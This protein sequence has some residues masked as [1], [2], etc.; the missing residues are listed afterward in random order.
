MLR[1]AVIMTAVRC[2]DTLF[3]YDLP[4]VV[5][6]RDEIGGSYVG[7]LMANCHDRYLVTGV[8]PTQLQRFKR[9]E[10]DLRSIVAPSA[11][12]RYF[13][14][15]G[16]LS[17]PLALTPM[18]CAE[19][20]ERHLPEAGFLLHD[21]PA[22]TAVVAEARSRNNFVLDLSVDPP[23]SADGHRIAANTLTGLLQHIQTLIKHAYGAALREL[24]APAR[25]E[26]DRSDAARLDVIVPAAPGSFRIVLE[27]GRRADLLGDSELTR[28]MHRVDLLFEG[29]DHPRDVLARLREHKG[30]LAGAFS[31]LVKFLASHDTSLV[32]QWATPGLETA[33]TRRVTRSQST[34]LVELLSGVSN[35]GS[36]PIVLEGLLE[37]ADLTRRSWRLLIDGARE[38]GTVAEGGPTL[39]GLKLGARYRF[40]C[41]EELDEAD[42]TGR[43]TRR[44]YLT[45]YTPIQ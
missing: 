21:A 45:D 3:F 5:E 37:E 2:T 13:S 19:D 22:A 36:E 25:R 9:G 32:Y 28:A 16:P 26:I 12:G 39:D 1:G 11:T 44:V 43:E 14:A 38:S 7:I 8:E 27:A 33:R 23:E 41:I 20:V 30:H 31:R 17:E 29:L 15:Q 24:P 34:A 42:A 40:E 35:L 4:Q 6:A 18:D 10:I